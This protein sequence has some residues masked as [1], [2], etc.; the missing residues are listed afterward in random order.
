MINKRFPASLFNYNFPLL[1]GL[2]LRLI[3]INAPIVGVHSWR[4]ADTAAMA[5]H[6]AL[7]N[8]PIW[9]PQI[10]WS[11]SAQGYVE[12]EFPIFPYIVGQ[13]YKIFG[14]HE[15]IGR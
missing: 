1:L 12:S 13:L 5:R 2:A 15:W 8:T 6:F 10:D 14:I 4:Q 3:N 7:E 9:L 11:G